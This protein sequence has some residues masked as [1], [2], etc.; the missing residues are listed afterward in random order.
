[1]EINGLYKETEDLGFEYRTRYLNSIEQFIKKG[2]EKANSSR[3]TPEML[4][5]NREEYR[6]RYKQMLGIPE[7][8]GVCPAADKKYVGED[9]L[10]K[11]YRLSI[12]VM[13]DFYFYGML[14]VPYNAEKAP[15]VIAQ[16]GGGGS[17]EFCSDMYGENNYSGFTKRALKK[18]AVVFA[19]QILVWGFGGNTGENKPDFN[20]SYDRGKIDRELKHLG[21]SI[22]GLEIFCIMRSLDYL[23]TLEE[24]DENRV[25]MMGLSY[26]GF[27]SMYTAA[28]D[29][30]IKAIYSAAAFNDRSKVCFMDWMWQNSANM[31]FDAEVA[32]LC[33]PRKLCIDVGKNDAVFDYAPSVNEGERAKQ[34]YKAASVPE[35]FIYNLWEG[36]HRF[37]TDSGG[38][39]FFFKAV[40]EG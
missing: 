12:E 20:I 8:G 36:E 35:N 7:G 1:M 9:S 17:P 37:D 32:G 21:Y 11:I 4:S 34:F 39:D 15:L 26:G 19:P 30:R 22:T 24:V 33:A 13:E 2:Y 3:C 18:G 28:A 14:F 25:G 16:H 31:F 10:C 5:T 6:V 38:F 29:T 40:F 27:Y 23:L